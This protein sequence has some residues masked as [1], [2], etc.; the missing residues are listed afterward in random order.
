[1]ES[2]SYDPYVNLCT[3]IITIYCLTNAFEVPYLCL[4]TNECIHI[5]NSS[6]VI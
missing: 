4:I 1:M 3:S 5:S 6:D 2:C